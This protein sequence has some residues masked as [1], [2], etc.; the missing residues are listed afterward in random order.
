MRLNPVSSDNALTIV[1]SADV[2]F[3]TLF[4]KITG[5]AVPIR[6][7]IV[8]IYNVQ[9]KLTFCAPEVPESQE[10]VKVDLK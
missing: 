5:H 2:V 10:T 8:L 3:W 7:G 4:V 6:T 1:E 9:Q